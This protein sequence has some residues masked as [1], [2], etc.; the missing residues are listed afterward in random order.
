MQM[1]QKDQWVYTPQ[2]PAMQ[3]SIADLMGGQMALLE[4]LKQQLS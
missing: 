1:M 3:T 2:A 4:K